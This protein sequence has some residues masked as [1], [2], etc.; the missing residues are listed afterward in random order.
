MNFLSKRS[1]CLDSN[2]PKPDPDL[3][4]DKKINLDKIFVTVPSFF[5]IVQIWVIGSDEFLSTL[6]ITI[7]R[8]LSFQDYIFTHKVI[9][10]RTKY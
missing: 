7:L 9:L 2:Q 1:I 4:S 3:N 5:R 8:V 10:D 6:T